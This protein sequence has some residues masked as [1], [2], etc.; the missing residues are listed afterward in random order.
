MVKHWTSVWHSWYRSWRP[1]KVV[2]DSSRGST[3]SAARPDYVDASGACVPCCGLGVTSDDVCLACGGTGRHTL[4]P[5][6]NERVET[7]SGSPANETTVRPAADLSHTSAPTPGALQAAIA[8]RD[9]MAAQRDQAR[10]ALQQMID[11]LDGVMAERDAVQARTAALEADLRLA[12]AGV[13]SA[14][15]A[16]RRAEQDKQAWKL[17]FRTVHSELEHLRKAVLDIMPSDEELDFFAGMLE[18]GAEGVEPGTVKQW[19]K[20]L[21]LHAVLR[22]TSPETQKQLNTSVLETVLLEQPE[23]QPSHP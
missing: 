12:E 16:T 2:R 6:W 1:G 21:S 5:E 18:H 22:D 10:R 15:S 8:E 19:E 7:P 23:S 4:R 17:A 14:L 3:T 9:A 20:W 13:V 11:A